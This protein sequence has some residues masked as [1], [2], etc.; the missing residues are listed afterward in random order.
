VIICAPFRNK[1]A[2]KL[3]HVEAYVTYPPSG[4]VVGDR[5]KISE[6]RIKVPYPST[7]GKKNSSYVRPVGLEIW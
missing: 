7:A 2:K 6:C 5:W 3:P 1:T 4:K